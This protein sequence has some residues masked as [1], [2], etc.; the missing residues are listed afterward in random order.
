MS[1]ESYLLKTLLLVFI[2]SQANALKCFEC[3]NARTDQECILNG[4]L[5]TCLKNENS[6]YNEV[7]NIHGYW[8]ITKRCKQ[9]LACENN[10]IQNVRDASI[11]SQ[12]NPYNGSSVCRCCC[13]E[14]A[15][16]ADGLFCLDKE[17]DC[18]KAPEVEFGLTD[19]TYQ[20]RDTEIGSVCTFTCLDGYTLIGPTV[21]TCKS[22]PDGPAMFDNPAP[23]CQKKGCPVRDG[24]ENGISFCSDGSS[25]G[26]QCNYECDSG[27]ALV[28]ESFII[29]DAESGEWSA[30]L[31]ICKPIKCGKQFP[32]AN[33][34]MEC[35]GN[36]IGDTC[37]FFCDE[38]FALIGSPVLDCEDDGNNDVTGAWSDVAPVCQAITC[39]PPSKAPAFG[40]FV[41]DNGNK[42]LSVCNYNCDPGFEIVGSSSRVCNDDLDG[43]IFGVW[44][45]PEPTCE[46]ITCEPPSSAP[47]FGVVECS[48]ENFFESICTYECL[49]G[50]AFVDSPGVKDIPQ[51]SII[52]R[53][54]GA[55][56]SWSREEP[57]CEIITCEPPSKSPTDGSV[58][59]SDSNFLSSVC[60]YECSAGFALVGSS[61]RVCENDSD[62]DALGEWSQPEPTC[63]PIICLPPHTELLNGDVSCTNSNNFESICTFTCNPGF[64]LEGAPIVSCGDDGDGDTLGEWSDSPPVCVESKC[65]D[66]GPLK[67]G[68]Y[69]CSD[70]NAVFSTCTFE[71]DASKGYELYPPELDQNTCNVLPNGSVGWSPMPCCSRPCPPYTL[72]DLVIVLD[73]SSSVTTP[74][75]ITQTNFARTLIKLFKMGADSTALSVFRYNKIVDEDSEIKFNDVENYNSTQLL[76]LFD[77]IPYNGR[78]TKTGQALQHA[79]D[80]SL[81]AEYGNRPGIQ[82]VVLVITD[83]KAEDGKLVDEVAKELRDQGVLIYAVGIGLNKATYKKLVRMTGDESRTIN[84]K[85]FDALLA[86]GLAS[87]FGSTLCHDPCAT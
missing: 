2:L 52:V 54:C 51:F 62:G 55:D 18:E 45:E 73:S 40:S 61:S 34:R 27:Y 31:P 80:K 41:C 38:G 75:W 14:D 30:P 35:T 36:L 12:C 60:D 10:Y 59:C 19:C 49:P 32:P 46:R 37:S 6:C 68:D 1:L 70:D 87:T 21:S 43:D 23:I 66:F 4:S 78:G 7:R 3:E 26:S 42:H 79:L 25:P 83:G 15:C 39:E 58:S 76:E 20:A 85:S 16:N 77:K 63:E 67:N 74:N 86:G 57:I 33:G 82:D 47:E 28:G 69:S 24:I 56:G 64:E 13:Q 71:C 9:T 53:N 17:P 44:S 8:L 65:V 11:K 72:M 81:S 48:N 5:V 29:C 22:R 84:P 50:Y